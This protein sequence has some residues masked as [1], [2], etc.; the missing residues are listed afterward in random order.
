MSTQNQDHDSLINGGP[1]D[2][3]VHKLNYL[4]AII[5]QA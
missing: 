2:D 5:K 3:S 1:W 4:I